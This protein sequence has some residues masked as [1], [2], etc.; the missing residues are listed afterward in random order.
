MAAA[1]ETASAFPA[2]V[3]GTRRRARLRRWVASLS[4]KYAL[5]FAL[6]AAVPLVATSAY[7]LD[8]SYNQRKSDLIRLQE[9]KAKSIAAGFE[10]AFRAQIGRLGSIHLAGVRATEQQDLLKPLILAD[11]NV[12]GVSYVDGAGREEARV[13]VRGLGPSSANL[14]HQTFF[15]HARRFGQYVGNVVSNGQFSGTG[16]LIPNGT[17]QIAAPENSGPGVVREI[18][19]PTGEFNDLTAGTKLGG[20]GYAYA[21]DAAG[22]PLAYTFIFTSSL[23]SS[24][25]L[26][27]VTNLPQ[28]ATALHSGASTGWTTG[29]NVN[30]VHKTVLS[31]WATVE[32]I[33][34]KVFVEQP[35][36]EVFAPLSG[37][38][39]R[40]VLL[41]LA[42]VAAAIVLSLLL[43]RRLVGP[44]RRMQVAA[45]AIGAGAYEE[46]VP[47]DRRDELGALARTLNTMAASLQE[48][49]GG[50]EAKVAERTHELEVASKHKSEFLANMSHELRT[51]LNAI[52]GFSQVLQEQLFGEVNDKQREYLDDILSSANHLLSLINDIL[53]LSK[54]EAGQVELEPAAFSLRESL[55]RG[56]VMVREKAANGGIALDLELDPS[57]DVIVGDER[58]ARQV[59]FNLLSNAVKFTPE[60]GRVEV[61]TRRQGDEVVVSVRDT[62]PG[63]APEDQETIFEEFRQVRTTGGE[64]PEGTGLGLALSRRLVELHG[65]RLWVESEPGSGST[66][67]FTLPVGSS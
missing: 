55:E 42:F 28:V 56:L 18:L 59:V 35:E 37:T 66:F 33:G 53:D 6:L 47:V 12:V 29:R 16:S 58:R 21:I 64:R 2:G 39:W 36:S 50:L 38:I 4:A 40:T 65:G 19:D 10:Q 8:S 54:V 63:I 13:T 60:G 43:A 62:G 15:V 11:P 20:S 52:V 44:I 57:V 49:I 41:L 14:A 3:A 67:S 30:F 45:A 9:E 23:T 27:R 51:P 32:P 61:S 1:G 25:V 5:L 31:A 7:L 26:K 22:T 34:W 48:L 46:R 17:I 24:G